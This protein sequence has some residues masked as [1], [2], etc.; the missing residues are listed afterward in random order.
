VALSLSSVIKGSSA[1]T[2][3]PGFTKT[4]MTSR[5]M[6]QIIQILEPTTCLFVFLEMLKADQTDFNPVQNIFYPF[7]VTVV[8]GF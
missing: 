5:Q 3:S 7:F 4:S 6:F 8:P 2:R 1:L